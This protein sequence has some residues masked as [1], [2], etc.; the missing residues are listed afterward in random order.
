MPTLAG[1]DASLV[2][3][4]ASA[5]G[6]V[7]VRA[8]KAVV[9]APPALDNS[10][11]RRL[12]APPMALR[13]CDGAEQVSAVQEWVPS[14]HADV[15]TLADL[16]RRRI[17]SF[18]DRSRARMMYRL[19]TLDFQELPG[20][21]EMV[22][23]T[24]GAH[25][26]TDGEVVKAHLWSFLKRWE[27]EHGARPLGVWKMEFQQRGA[28]HFHLYVGRPVMDW[29]KF[30][31]WARKAWN[32]VVGEFGGEAHLRQGVRLD[33]QFVAAV[34]SKGK[35][36]GYFAKHNAKGTKALQ[37][38][39]PEG[40]ENV[41]RWWGTLGMRVHVTEIEVTLP[42]MLQMRRALVGLRRSRR[43]VVVVNGRQKMIGRNVKAPGRL[44]GL[45]SM[46]GDG[47][48]ILANLLDDVPRSTFLE[49]SQA[50]RKPIMPV[51]V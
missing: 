27:R 33:R 11:D 12:L 22:T 34:R 44:I 19:S 3:L 10:S 51:R 16:P 4:A 9:V 39:I 43:R 35:I 30:R 45:W 14:D 36:A 38:Q 32:E 1:S 47:Y 42:V 40:F 31:S 49:Y 17:R 15:D 13:A 46:A 28:P 8:T 24:Y 2:F 25:F 37:N 21:P 41:G 6:S 5:P 18:S 29:R 50:G 26:P 48:A 23:L 7:R 20:I